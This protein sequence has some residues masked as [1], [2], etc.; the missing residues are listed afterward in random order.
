V[1]GTGFQLHCLVGSQPG[2]VLDLKPGMLCIGRGRPG[3]KRYGWL[4]LDDPTVSRHHAN[5]NWLPTKKRFSYEH[6]SKTNPSRINGQLL[7]GD[8]FLGTNAQITIGTSSFLLIR[9][10]IAAPLPT[11]AK[12]SKKTAIEDLDQ[13]VYALQL[14]PNGFT[15]TLRKDGCN[16]IGVGVE[17]SWHPT[18]RHFVVEMKG[19]AQVRLSRQSQNL[20][21]NDLITHSAKLSHGDILTVD[22]CQ[23]RFQ[24]IQPEPDSI[25]TLTMSSKSPV[26]GYTEQKLIGQG[27][28]G[29]VFHY[30]DLQGNSV[31]IKFLAPH[32]LQD[33]EAQIRFQNEAKVALS[34]N[35]PCLLRVRAVGDSKDGRK[36]ML[37][38]Y[39]PDGTLEDRL[40]EGR[41]LS[42]K[43]TLG[44]AH[45]IGLALD[46]L[47]AKNLVHRDVKPSNIF[48]RDSRAVLADFGIVKGADLATATHSGF[49]AGTP[50]YMSPEQF[51]GFTE[52]RSDQ[53]ALGVVLYELL[54]GRKLF[55][56]P[57]PIALAYMHVHEKPKALSRLCPRIPVQAVEAVERMLKKNP[58]ERFSTL[59]EAW[60]HLSAALR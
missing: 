48:F 54:S 26:P 55:E 58:K 19:G 2:L 41:R 33:E 50:Q 32:L 37:S 36:Y 24:E 52:P 45:D 13:T 42:L 20:E 8:L 4:L 15:D 31:A 25:D 39:L 22:F 14:L 51:R 11:A 30:K 10:S 43:E 1:P 35:H 16:P 12:K 28:H 3:E 29:Q 21:S 6:I 44:V 56:A 49:T 38:E 57:E 18:I 53:Y 17:V 7:R 40:K 9:K 47:H 27:S 5:L 23:F 60:T 59:A 34:L 46:Y